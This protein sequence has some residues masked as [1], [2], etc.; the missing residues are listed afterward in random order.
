MGTSVALCHSTSLSMVVNSL[1]GLLVRLPQNKAGKD[2]NPSGDK[3]QKDLEGIGSKANP[4]KFIRGECNVLQ[5]G[6][7]NGFP[8]SG[9]GRVIDKRP[10]ET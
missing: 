7:K 8:N 4:M 1:D 9:I 2:S 6:S 5:L 10:E 3:M